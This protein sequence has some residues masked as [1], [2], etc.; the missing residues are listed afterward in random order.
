M[1]TTQQENLEQV[2]V[3]EI[4]QSNAVVVSQDEVAA[5]GLG[6]VSDKV[7]DPDSPLESTRDVDAG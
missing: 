7:A 3:Y 1:S 5:Y 4:L 6:V 2:T